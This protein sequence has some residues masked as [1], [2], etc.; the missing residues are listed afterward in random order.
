MESLDCFTPHSRPRGLI[1][2]NERRI[3]IISKMKVIDDGV[4]KT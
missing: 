2:E 4:W 3:W 1:Y